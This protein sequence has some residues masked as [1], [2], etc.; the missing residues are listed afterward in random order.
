MLYLLSSRRSGAGSGVVLSRL[1]APLY[2]KLVRCISLIQLTDVDLE[3]AHVLS[4]EVVS[5]VFGV[6]LVL[7]IDESVGA[8]L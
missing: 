2:L 6:T 1:F 7:E 4:V 8:L 5:G 3:T